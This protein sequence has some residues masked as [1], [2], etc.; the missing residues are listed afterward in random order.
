[1]VE[2]STFIV[3]GGDRRLA[4][5][6]AMLAADGHTVRTY[7][8]STGQ[9]YSSLAEAAEGA[10]YAVLPLPVADGDNLNTA[11]ESACSLEEAFD[12]LKRC[13]IVF[14]G[15]VGNKEELL[16]KERSIN[17]LDYYSREELQVAN[18]VPTAEGAIAIAMQEIPVTLWGCDVLVVGFG[19]I[20]KILADRL[21]GLGACVTVA[22]RRA[23]QRVWA[24]AY[25]YRASSMHELAYEIP[26]MRV[27]FNT[28]PAPVI[29]EH[30]LHSANPGTLFIDLA[31][32]P[33]GVDRNAAQAFGLRVIHA[34]SLPGKTAFI[35]SGE[36]IKNTI[37][38]M[39]NEQYVE[40]TGAL[41]DG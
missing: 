9:T 33:G 37:Y 6:A 34:L 39:L 35:T 25:G 20:G 27:V 30:V 26:G 32:K 40:R 1:M 41:N 5:L 7:A 36:I 21:K 23:S 31:S 2:K 14:A 29:G 12:A 4:E 16:A 17:L 19:R 22:A 28:V 3:A 38:N 18:A 13:Q 24:E 10:R 11:R 15:K 8:L